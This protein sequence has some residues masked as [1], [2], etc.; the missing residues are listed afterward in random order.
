MRGHKFLL[1]DPYISRIF[2]K[3]QQKHQHILKHISSDGRVAIQVIRGGFINVQFI[4]L[5]QR[6]KPNQPVNN[7]MITSTW[8]GLL[9]GAN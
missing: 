5:G 9:K 1:S 3:W 6:D 4:C 8:M 2:S 7:C